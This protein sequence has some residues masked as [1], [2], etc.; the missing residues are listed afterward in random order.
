MRVPKSCVK[1]GIDVFESP[2][3]ERILATR[4]GFAFWRFARSS[5]VSRSEF[6]FVP[7]PF[8]LDVDEP[9]DD[10][11]NEILGLGIFGRTVGGVPLADDNG[12]ISKGFFLMFGDFIGCGFVTGG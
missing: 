5:P 12:T 2:D 3:E 8:E 6:G 11:P 1:P 9:E 4:S 10:G 7:V